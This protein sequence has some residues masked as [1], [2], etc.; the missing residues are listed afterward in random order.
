[1]YVFTSPSVCKKMRLQI[2]LIV[3]FSMFLLHSLPSFSWGQIA[4]KIEAPNS[5]TLSDK[6]TVRFVLTNAKGS[7]FKD[8][9]VEG[10][11]TLYPPSKAM[12]EREFNGKPSTIYTGT[13][14]AEKVGTIHI[15]SAQ[16]Q[17]KG[18]VYKTSPLFIKVLPQEKELK[19][20]SRSSSSFF[21]RTIPGHTTV[22]LQEGILVSYKIYARSNRF[23]FE[24]SKFPEYDGF[25]EEEIKTPLQSQLAMEHYN[26]QN[27]YTAIIRQSVIMPQRSGE[28]TIPEGEINLIVALEK[29]IEN[30]DEFFDTSST[31]TD[32][33][34]MLTPKVKIKVLD[35]PQPT[36]ENFGGGVGS[37][38]IKAELPDGDKVKTDEPF[39]MRVTIAGKGNLKLLTPP[40]L[41]L[42]ES[43]EILDQSSQYDIAASTD[44]IKGQRVIE[45]Q[46]NPR[47]TGNYSIPSLSLV[48]FDP[49]KK[50]YVTEQTQEISFSVKKGSALAYEEKESSL[51][52]SLEKDIAPLQKKPFYN[53][54]LTQFLYSPFYWLFYLIPLSIAFIGGWGYK[55]YRKSLEDVAGTKCRKAAKSTMQRLRNLEKE[56]GKEENSS[57]Y[58]S[59]LSSVH[60]Y[61]SDKFQIPT[62]HLSTINIRE[63]LKAT[64]CSEEVIEEFLEVI[65]QVEYSRYAPTGIDLSPSSLLERTKTVIETIES[66]K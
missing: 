45:Y 24:Q 58:A 26:G 54:S 10:V 63:K 6:I 39:R 15:G 4:F 36:P 49:A 52:L 30:E 34:K 1:M 60:T 29:S 16:V 38:S 57:F 43:F 51:S 47:N 19:K 18:K 22:Y 50:R 3:L 62:S 55:R 20:Q 14:L 41:K 53:K 44:G 31:P 21:I 32:R 27:Y 5:V 35:L 33:K 2:L 56:I 40:T 61:L 48:Y 59:L 42:P 64:N 13:Y 46:I 66:K 12:T 28:L 11:S 7:N 23:E 9:E 8:P 17:A 25:V 65:Q 37:F